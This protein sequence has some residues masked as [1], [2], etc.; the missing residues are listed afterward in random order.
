MIK[1]GEKYSMVYY[2]LK[3]DLMMTVSSGLLF[4]TTLYM[5]AL[6]GNYYSQ[7]RL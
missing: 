6:K 7:T 3:Y 4:W 2:F 5:L 1:I